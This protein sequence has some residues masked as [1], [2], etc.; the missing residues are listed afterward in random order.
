MPHPHPTLTIDQAFDLVATNFAGTD[1]DMVGI[2]VEWPLHHAREQASARPT[3]SELTPLLS[4]P[5]PHRGRITIEPGGQVE[6]STS[7]Q[8]TATDAITALQTDAQILH[9]QL[10]RR[11]WC[12]ADLAFDDRRPPARIL[13]RPRYAAMEAFFAHRGDAGTQMMTNT[14]SVQINISHD[15]QGGHQRWDLANRIGP[16]L[17]AMFANSPGI[18]H[19]GMHWQSRRQEIW[20]RI[21]PGRTAPLPLSRSPERDWARYALGADVFFVDTGREGIALPPG[22]SFGHWLTHGHPLGWPSRADLRY[23]LTTLFPPIRPRGW[24]ELR[25]LDA[26]PPDL[27]AAAVHIVCAAMTAEVASELLATL[28]DTRHLWTIGARSGLAHSTLRTA[29]LTLLDTTQAFL[30]QTPGHCAAAEMVGAFTDR[31]TRRGLAPAD[32]HLRRAV[33]SSTPALFEPA[34]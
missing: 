13:D 9:A 32:D 19:D 23:H 16:L 30:R 34:L 29:A 3:M 12:P 33:G 11:G 10:R 5:L 2:E 14:A 1:D 26:L 7:P 27:R 28:P 18:G 8:P 25:M 17:I 22:L 21:D 6:L 15:P 31:Y 20:S 24:L 4:T